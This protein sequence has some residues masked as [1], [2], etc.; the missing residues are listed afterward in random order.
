MYISLLVGSTD[1][2]ALI[3]SK[4]G[5]ECQDQIF[6]QAKSLTCTFDPYIAIYYRRGEGLKLSKFKQDPSWQFLFYN[7]RTII[8][9]AA[10]S[11]MIYAITSKLNFDE[12]IRYM[13]L[14]FQLMVSCLPKQV[15]F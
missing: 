9:R 7:K 1:G 3:E 13:Y 8:R 12:L 6:F 10:N 5:L 14:K 4:A 11:Y 15:V 2:F